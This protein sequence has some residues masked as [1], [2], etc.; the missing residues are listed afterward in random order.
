MGYVI[1]ITAIC[2]AEHFIKRYVVRNVKPGT[3]ILKGNVTVQQHHNKGMAFNF[4]EKQVH[5]VKI[6]TGTLIGLLLVLLGWLLGQKHRFLYK[7]G[8]SLILGGALS[9]FIDRMKNG[10]VLDYFSFNKGKKLKNIVFNMA[11]LSVFLGAIMVAVAEL[12]HTKK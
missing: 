11:D 5:L 10:D 2:I 9:N 8:L 3:K 7:L 6:I 1:I 12:V 4:L